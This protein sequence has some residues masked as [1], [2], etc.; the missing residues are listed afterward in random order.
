[1]IGITRHSECCEWNEENLDCHTCEGRY[2]VPFIIL[3]KG[4]RLPFSRE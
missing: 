3:V 4:A 2:P 1:M